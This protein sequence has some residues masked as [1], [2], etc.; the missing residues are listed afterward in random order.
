MCCIQP[1]TW[2]MAGCG[3]CM[4]ARACS[5]ERQLVHDWT[6]HGWTC[7]IQPR[8]LTGSGSGCCMRMEACGC[9]TERQL[10]QACQ[11]DAIIQRQDGHMPRWHGICCCQQSTAALPAGTLCSLC[12]HACA[13][14]RHAQW[15]VYS[16]HH[17]ARCAPLQAPS[18]SCCWARSVASA[19]TPSSRGWRARWASPSCEQW[20]A[21]GL[22]GPGIAAELAATA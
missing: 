18:T 15:H 3:M 2:H 5:T 21:P 16:H 4:E 19:W 10:V 1:R 14:H 7:C 12:Y 8:T 6:G 13:V 20:A 9:S 22:P 17:P 11:A